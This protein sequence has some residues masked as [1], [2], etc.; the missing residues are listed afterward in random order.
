MKSSKFNHPKYWSAFF[1]I[2]N[3]L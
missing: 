1:A 3:G 2:G